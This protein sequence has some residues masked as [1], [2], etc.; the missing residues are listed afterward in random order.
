MPG[1]LRLR[2]IQPIENRQGEC[3]LLY[4][5]ER[6]QVFE[7]P[8]EF[9]LHAAF[10]LDKGELD[11]GLIGWLASEDLMTY[12]VGKGEGEGLEGSS[13]S[14]LSELASGCVYFLGGHVHGQLRTVS[15]DGVARLLDS[16]NGRLNGAQHITLHLNAEDSLDTLN[17]AML[18]GIL[19][20]VDRRSELMGCQVDYELTVMPRTVTPE[21]ADLLASHPF[22]VRARCDGPRTVDGVDLAKGTAESFSGVT[23]RGLR[24]LLERLDERLI[25][26]AMLAEE[27]RLAYLWDWARELGVQRLHVT[28]RAPERD[29]ARGGAEADLR[30]FRAD[31][32]AVCDEMFFT[33]E[34]GYSAVLY[35]PI[36]RVVRRMSEKRTRLGTSAP[37]T[38]SLGFVANGQVVPFFGR[39]D[40]SPGFAPILDWATGDSRDDTDRSEDPAGPCGSCWARSLCGHGVSADPALSPA[41]TL[42]ARP[43]H[44]DFWRA[45]IEAGLLFYHR[46]L[47][48]DPD[49]LLGLA[50]PEVGGTFDP[51]DASE[52]FFEWKTC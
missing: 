7:V 36:L 30:A 6:N 47:E 28:K 1:G 27:G 32:E 31:L 24:M 29:D 34:A 45:E 19:Q 33:L 5:L 38:A 9:Q 12:E 2:T 51:F 21:M 41:E 42:G 22:R 20:E 4:D 46:V 23:E 13:V 39:S 50:E 37:S 14:E 26:H 25:V 15:R 35:E 3:R 43:E 11:E 52:R 17:A 40:G 49:Y 18:R 44:C 10:A 48:A 16:L 8:L